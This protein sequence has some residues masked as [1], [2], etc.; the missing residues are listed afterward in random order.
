VVREA[1]TRAEGPTRWV[2]IGQRGRKLLGAAA[3]QAETMHAPEEATA[4]S[5][6]REVARG[7]LG[8]YQQQPQVG[9]MWLIAARFISATRQTVHAYPLLPLPTAGVPALVDER[10]VVIEPTLDAVLQ[11]LAGCWVSALCVEAY[12]SARRAELAARALHVEA[13]RQ[14][15]LQRSAKVRH[16]FFKTVHERVDRLVRETC[17]VRRHALP[18]A[19]VTGA[20]R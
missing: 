8:Y 12:W 2:L 19:R 14:E 20:V 3:A 10:P 7:L 17:V 5:Q 13:S 15:L 18:R 6:M 4:E 1:L 9:E 11:A 16:E